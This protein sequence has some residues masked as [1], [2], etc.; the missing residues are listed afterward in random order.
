MSFDPSI[1][2]PISLAAVVKQVPWLNDVPRRKGSRLHQST[3]FRWALHGLRGVRLEVI[4]FGGQM[5]TSEPALK[6]F[7]AALSGT[8]A[9][10]PA[11]PTPDIARQHRR[12]EAELAAAGIGM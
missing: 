1:E 4:R 5:C 2:R 12:A 10:S 3:V 6:R 9:A 11:S 7:F 8:A